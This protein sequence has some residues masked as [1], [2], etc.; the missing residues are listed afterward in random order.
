MSKVETFWH[1]SGKQHCCFSKQPN[2][3]ETTMLVAT[4]K[5]QLIKAIMSQRGP[6]F[7]TTTLKNR[8][9]PKKKQY[10]L[11]TFKSSALC[12]IKWI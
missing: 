12:P 3:S 1:P 6:K 8:W 7:K 5:I 10:F 2:V 9:C 11:K 4:C